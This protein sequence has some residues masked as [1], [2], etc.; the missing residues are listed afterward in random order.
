MANREPRPLGNR[1]T[2]EC[3]KYN[4]A[5]AAR[6]RGLMK[7]NGWKQV[8]LSRHLGIGAQTIHRVL[9]KDAYGELL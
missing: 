2:P 1:K 6:W 8:E 5:D 4:S 7:H 9:E 3:H